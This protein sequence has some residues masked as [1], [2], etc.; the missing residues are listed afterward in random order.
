MK[1]LLFLLLTFT[2]IANAQ[3][4]PTE[5]SIAENDNK[6]YRSTEV[7]LK[8]QLKEGVYTISLFI[9]DKFKFPVAIKNKKITIFSSFV[10]EKDGSMTDVKAFYIKIKDLVESNIKKAKT[11]D[12]K[13][14]ELDEI[15]TMKAETVRVLSQFKATW[16]PALKYGRPVRCLYNLPL[17][18][19]VE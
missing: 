16:T 10:I 3:Q 19:S 9:S 8:P 5:N 17:N 7:E 6:I 15:E 2:I 12:E 18:F 14:N 11:S 13:I 4:S 1:Q